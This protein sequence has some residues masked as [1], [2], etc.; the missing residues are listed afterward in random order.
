VVLLV[1]TLLDQQYIGH[2]S[3]HH[4]ELFLYQLSVIF[5]LKLITLLLVAAVPVVIMQV[6]AVA[7]VRSELV[8]LDIH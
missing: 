4:Q 1:T 7:L 3:L 6:V 2:I 5:L 8:Y